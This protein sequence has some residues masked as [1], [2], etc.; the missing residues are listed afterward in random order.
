MDNTGETV[1]TDREAIKA[2]MVAFLQT[3]SN[4]RRIDESDVISWGFVGQETDWSLGED[5]IIELSR[6]N[7]I[8]TYVYD[9]SVWCRGLKGS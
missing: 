2:K 6:D 1:M 5:L 3:K 4:C 7:V 8:E 9:G